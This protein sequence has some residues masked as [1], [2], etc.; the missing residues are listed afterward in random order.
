MN[1]RK[2]IA[3]LMVFL[4]AGLLG[5]AIAHAAREDVTVTA[6]FNGR[7]IADASTAAPLR[8]EPG[9]LAKVDLEVTNNGERPLVVKRV[10][11]SGNILGL[12][13]YRYVASTE[14]T[15]APGTTGSLSYQ[16]DLTDL[17]TLATGLIRGDLEVSDDAGRVIT[18]I[19]TVTDVGG[20]LWSVTGL[21]GLVL[22][23]FTVVAFVRVG[24]A[25]ARH[26]LPA[27]RAQRGLRFLLPGVG[28]LL[29]LGFTASVLRLWTPPAGLWWAVTG[30]GAVVFF[31]LGYFSPMPGDDGGFADGVDFD[32]LTDQFTEDFS[33]QHTD[34]LIGYQDTD[35]LIDR[36]S[37]ERAESVCAGEASGS[38][39]AGVVTVGDTGERAPDEAGP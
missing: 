1:T 34:D 26:R 2:L 36:R 14:L 25:V 31:V 29:V 23:I 16:V 32:Q 30:I 10:E 5:S 38:E 11:L 33:E 37:T 6:T 4:V 21:F 35:D 27:N 20:S 24:T 17:D 19:P 39:R 9:T 15:V 13:F 12:N 28:L 3:A 18:T 8:L 7:D 22:I